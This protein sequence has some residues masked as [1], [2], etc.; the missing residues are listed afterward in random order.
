MYKNKAFKLLYFFITIAVSMVYFQPNAGASDGLDYT[1]PNGLKVILLEN[2]RAPVTSMLVWVKVGSVSE[3]E[4][5]YGL[6]HLMEHMMF[7]GTKVR[8]PGEIAREVESSGGEINAYTSYDQTVYYI[9]MASRF[10]DKGLE[11]LSDMV[12]NPVFDP[13][14]FSREKEVV[15]EELRRGEDS[16]QRN[17]SKTL[18][19]AAFPNHPYGRPIIGFS[20]DVKGVS[21][22]QALDFYHKHYQPNN[23]VLVMAGDFS[24]GKV[25][26]VIEKYFGRAPSG[27]INPEPVP[28]E[29]PQKEL[30]TAVIRD[31]VNTA[32]LSLAFRIP[33]FRS[34]DS[35]A[36]DML[37]SILG[38]GRTSRL[39]VK[40]LRKEELVNSI[41]AG[42]YT[43]DGPGL[44][45]IS[46]DLSPENVPAAAKAIV[47]EVWRLAREG[48]AA[49]ELERAKLNAL[50]SSI[51][52]RASMSGEAAEAAEWQV[53]GGDFR[54]RDQYQA[55]IEKLTTADLL[56][57]ATRYFRPENLTAAVLLPEDKEKDLTDKSLAAAILE[58][59]EGV[60]RFV[61]PGGTIL[62]VKPDHSLPLVAVRASFPGGLRCEGPLEQGLSNFTAEVWDRGAGDLGAEELDRK[63]EDM[64][65]DISSF[66]GRYSFGL[67]GD[68]LSRNIKPG[69]RL[70]TDVLVNPSFDAAEVEKARKNILAD[71]KRREDHL[72]VKSF[73]LFSETLFQGSPL[74]RDTLGT[75]ETAAKFKASDLRDFY[76]KWAR[77]D[78]LV[79]SVVGDVDPEQIKEDLEQLL[80]GW[81]G[82]PR[83]E[84]SPAAPASWTGL[85][86]AREVADKSQMHMVL[87]FPAPGLKSRDRFALEVLDNILSGQGG[88]LFVTL[89]DQRSLAYSLGS[90]YRP[91][92][93]VGSFGM[94]IGFEP[95]K[96]DEVR[97]GLREII[98]GVKSRAVSEKELDGAKRYLLGS[99][100]I[101]LQKYGA[102][103]AELG[104]NEL[105]GLGYD[106]QEDY[107]A[108]IKAVTPDDVLKAAQKYLDLNHAVEVMV[109]P[110]Q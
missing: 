23:M 41:M 11:I 38:Q 48:V 21:R 91:G 84:P 57:T 36:L 45:I 89:R 60:R 65:A 74:G 110:G 25:R 73:V 37:A 54:L 40:V 42:T 81:K 7:K 90:F 39:H 34:P 55:D 17:L 103:A 59:S 106:F 92:P 14:E 64:A 71:I 9:N 13:V 24:P 51:H 31:N 46:A 12:F 102:Q 78:D 15:L 93:S 77:P 80:S 10:Q 87:G 99:Y 16:P 50:A 69:L 3:K 26:P 98:E 68:F 44:F 70:F 97:S 8:G 67:E 66:S 1:L 22:E 30:R 108:G 100:D 19:A 86:T 52:Y 35:K 27:I 101:G 61:L 79:L 85:K 94:Y 109:G 47:D 33:G 53:L 49:D 18:F 32:K 104:Y 88:R 107:I 4:G 6:A 75:P 63:V 5:G 95:G 82:G 29:P 83:V 105:Y 62:L 20:S 28:M 56:K 76:K 72:M 2:H 43:P 96:L 58:Q